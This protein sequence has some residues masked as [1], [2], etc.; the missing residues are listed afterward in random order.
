M[1][2]ER[3]IG[4]YT[5]VGKG[6]LMIVFGAMHGNEPAG[7]EALKLMVKMLEVEPITNPQFTFRG[8]LLGLIG[9]TRALK[10]GKR[11]INK[12]LN[13]QWTSEN[14]QRIQSATEEFFPFRRMNEKV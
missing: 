2:L 14:V 12:D 1:E 9:N 13:R 5:G 11:Y 6:P 7:V 3:V 4:S 8:R 10:Q